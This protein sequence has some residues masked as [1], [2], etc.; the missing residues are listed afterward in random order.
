MLA[1][2]LQYLISGITVGMVYAFSALGFSLIYNASGV[3]NFAQGE[4][5]MLG[6]MLAVFF[7]KAGLPFPAA[8]V[9]A[10]VIP[11]LLGMMIERLT[12]AR[13]KNAEILSLIIITIGIS[14]VLRGLTQI[15]MGKAV[16]ALAP[17][18]DSRPIHLAGAVMHS[19]SPWVLG[20]T[21][22]VMAMLWYFF[23][24]SLSG[25][26][27]LATSC[28]R[29]AAQLMGINTQWVMT[30]S[31]AMAAAL[32]SLAGVLITPITMTSYDVGIMLG[33][34]GFIGAVVGGMGSGMG[35]IAGGLIV[36]IAESL[37]AGYISSAYKDAM[38]FLLIFVIL[39]LRPRGL[40]GAK[41][42]DRV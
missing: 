35:A 38:A 27:I 8:A 39:F 14:L 3:V 29:S 2:F 34:K 13:A 36:G 7:S 20:F 15:F 33:L 26:K 1:P 30:F 9:L 11:T 10:I 21:V 37:G 5:I 18:S 42:T 16:H 28:N 31:Y 19:Q 22:T 40:F 23:R 17:I 4:F 24:H 6:G 41:A 12:I 25:K 32:G